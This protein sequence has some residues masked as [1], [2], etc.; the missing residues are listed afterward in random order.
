MRSPR[1]TWFLASDLY[2][3]VQPLYEQTMHIKVLKE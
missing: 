3:H 2:D 1:G